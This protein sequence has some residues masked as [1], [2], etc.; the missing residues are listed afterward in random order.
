VRL[1]KIDPFVGTSPASR[2]LISVLGLTLGGHFDR[3][4]APTNEG[5]LELAF[6][7]AQCGEALPSAK[8]RTEYKGLDSQPWHVPSDVFPSITMSSSTKGNKS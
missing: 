4:S 3:P 7:L 5:F 8:M 2:K 1:A 6:M